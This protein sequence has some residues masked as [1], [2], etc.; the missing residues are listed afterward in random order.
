MFGLS[1]Y[2]TDR[3]MWELRERR[4]AL[5]LTIAE[6]DRMKSTG[7][8]VYFTPLTPIAC[9]NLTQYAKRQDFHF[10]RLYYST[11]VEAAEAGGCETYRCIGLGT[12]RGLDAFEFLPI[13]THQSDAN[14]ANVVWVI[15]T[16]KGY[17]RATYIE[18]SQIQAEA[19]GDASDT[20]PFQFCGDAR[21]PRGIEIDSKTANIPFTSQRGG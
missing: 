12:F 3:R 13:G 21:L 15:R 19:R 1:K 9:Q 10:I 11:E 4:S 17:V 7:R 2:E 5:H 6:F 18:M 16:P 20:S 8:I 14:A